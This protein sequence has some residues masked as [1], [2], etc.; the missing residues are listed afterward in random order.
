MRVRV[1][2]SSSTTNLPS[3]RALRCRLLKTLTPTSVRPGA[4]ELFSACVVGFPVA[5]RV[6]VASVQ[7]A[8]ERRGPSLSAGCQHRLPASLAHPLLEALALPV[9]AARDPPV[10][11][12]RPAVAAVQFRPEG[13]LLDAAAFGHLAADAGRRPASNRPCA[14]ERVGRLQPPRCPLGT[15]PPCRSQEQRPA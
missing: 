14:E 2:S 3:A 12:R 15:T 8:A 6:R 4:A 10:G 7:R 1:R 11:A 9:D 13:V 5:F